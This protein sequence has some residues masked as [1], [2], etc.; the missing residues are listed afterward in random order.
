L[1]PAYSVTSPLSRSKIE[2]E[3]SCRHEVFAQVIL[4]GAG[5][6]KSVWLALLLALDPVPGRAETGDRVKVRAEPDRVAA[7]RALTLSSFGARCSGLSR[8]GSSASLCFLG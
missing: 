2:Q 4:E 7:V 6:V 1:F 5:P 8:S 3:P